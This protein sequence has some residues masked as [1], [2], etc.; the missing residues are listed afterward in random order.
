MEILRAGGVTV[1]DDT[2]NSNPDSVLSSLQALKEMPCKGKK[3]V[4]LA[5]M[6]ELGDASRR[7]HDLIGEA[8]GEMGFEYLLTYGPMAKHASDRADVK[9]KAHYDQKNILSEYAATLASEGDIIL[10]KGSRG[11]KMED[12][13]VFL[14]ASKRG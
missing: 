8:V 11:M 3:I 10:V 13:V 2:Y 6:L 9:L 5:D 7:E 12:V 1:I 4:V 14:L